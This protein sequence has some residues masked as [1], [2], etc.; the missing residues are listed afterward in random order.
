VDEGPVNTS[1]FLNV[2]GGCCASTVDFVA[3]LV[4]FQQEYDFAFGMYAKSPRGTER[5]LVSVPTPSSVP[6]GVWPVSVPQGNWN[7]YVAATPNDCFCGEQLSGDWEVKFETSKGGSLLVF[8]GGPDFDIAPI[9]I[10]ADAE[11][12][13]PCNP[14]SG[15]FNESVCCEKHPSRCQPCEPNSLRPG[16][17]DD[18][19][20]CKPGPAFD[21]EQCSEPEPLCNPCNP[22]V[23]AFDCN[24]CS[25]PIPICD[26]CDPGAVN[27]NPTDPSC[28]DSSGPCDPSDPFC[29]PCENP[30]CGEEDPC[31]L[32]PCNCIFTCECGFTA[33]CIPD[34]PDFPDLDCE[35]DPF[36]PSCDGIFIFGGKGH[37][38]G[39]NTSNGIHRS[40][41][42][43]RNLTDSL[44][45]KTYSRAWNA[46]KAKKL[47]FIHH[48]ARAFANS[49]H[50]TK[51]TA[52]ASV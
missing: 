23:Q 19:N 10:F 27:Y 38:K 45:C 37:G 28:P 30:P 18:C 14:K 24:L 20:P 7:A 15:I 4:Q 29:G 48:A 42:S 1:I 49:T 39:N 13:D 8:P 26:P 35:I 44:N 50:V 47:H 12:C 43:H 11:Q 3:L 5:K 52:Q 25:E 40:H 34:F 17:E 36:A 41:R 46:S 22:L 31:L 33:A 6:G 32:D 9:I 16:S 51:R 2:E 21:C